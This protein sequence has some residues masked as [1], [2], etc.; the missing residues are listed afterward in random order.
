[1]LATTQLTGYIELKSGLM[2]SK[3]HS[4]KATIRD[5]GL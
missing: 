5:E 1:M 2:K 4:Q 3:M